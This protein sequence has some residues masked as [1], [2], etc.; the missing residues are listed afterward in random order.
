MIPL[1]SHF[2]SHWSIPLRGWLDSL[3][4]SKVPVC[5]KKFESLPPFIVLK[6]KSFLWYCRILLIR[7]P[8]LVQF[9]DSMCNFAAGALL[10]T[11]VMNV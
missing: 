3:V 2:F 7:V 11:N 8:V 6:Y 4:E 5:L 9:L 10:Q 1:S